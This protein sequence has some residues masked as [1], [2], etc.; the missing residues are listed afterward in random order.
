MCLMKAPKNFEKIAI[1]EMHI[2]RTYLQP[3]YGNGVF[4]NV[5]LSAGQHW[6]VNIAGT[7]LP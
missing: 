7:P 5:Y 6:E 4:G 1:I 2:V 3:H